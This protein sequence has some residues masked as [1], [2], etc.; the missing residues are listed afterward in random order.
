[1]RCTPVLFDY[2]LFSL[3][4]IYSRRIIWPRLST[5][6]NDPNVILLYYLLAILNNNGRLTINFASL[7]YIIIMHSMTTSISFVETY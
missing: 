4:Y 5:T 7:V 3:K 2:G 6:N 1:M